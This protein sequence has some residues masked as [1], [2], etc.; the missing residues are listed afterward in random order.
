MENK[1]PA[2][3]PRWFLIPANAFVAGGYSGYVING[4]MRP[5][6][7]EKDVRRKI[8]EYDFK[9]DTPKGFYILKA[10]V[11]LPVF[12][13]L[14]P[15]L[16]LLRVLSKEKINDRIIKF[17]QAAFHFLFPF[18]RH[19]SIT[20]EEINR[21]HDQ[22]TLYVDIPKELTA[23]HEAG[24]RIAL[25]G[26]GGA[27]SQPS[28][29]INKQM[30][31]GVVHAWIPG[32]GQVLFDFIRANADP[33]N[34]I[35]VFPSIGLY[36]NVIQHIPVYRVFKQQF[37]VWDPG[38]MK[39][40]IPEIS[41]SLRQ[42]LER[43]K[44]VYGDSVKVEAKAGRRNSE[45]YY[46][47][48]EGD[49]L[50]RGFIEDN[51]QKLKS[52]F[53]ARS[54]SFIYFPIDV[55]EKKDEYLDQL[56]ENLWFSAPELRASD[57]S[58]AR[59]ETAGIFSKADRVKIERCFFEDSGFP[60]F[61]G[62]VLVKYIGKN[63][64]TDEDL[65]TYVALPFFPDDSLLQNIVSFSDRL[66]PN[67]AGELKIKSKPQKSSD[68]ASVNFYEKTTDP[69]RDIS[70]EDLVKLQR[71]QEETGK[72]RLEEKPGLF[73]ALLEILT[74]HTDEKTSKRIRELLIEKTSRPHFSPLLITRDYGII[75]PDYGNMEISM[76]PLAKI[77]YF[78][79]LRHPEGLIFKNLV[80]HREE[81][82]E[83]YE[84]ITGRI[85]CSQVSRSIDDLVDATSPSVNQKA[86]RIRAAFRSRM[87]EEI[88]AHYYITGENSFPKRITA[89][90]G[91][92]KDE[93][94][95]I[96][97]RNT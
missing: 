24:F 62:P 58:R 22:T 59:M 48:Y 81:L 20:Y 93:S 94:G 69:E 31:S 49:E 92:L 40:E 82:C 2:S 19:K 53:E 84:K 86:A 28:P 74:K 32:S 85:V 57:F 15:V 65:F 33:R 72:L 71:I 67:H 9:P 14:S 13:L 80:D 12:L 1:I 3:R 55:E 54:L 97:R 70:R 61:G 79:F 18:Y 7:T 56:L 75:L 5:E 66:S 16:L 37:F 88:A 42:I 30:N 63:H 35:V 29:Y 91:F 76:Y 51:H 73:L 64:S 17:I 50:I 11:L 90:I 39:K 83:L 52:I 25:Y 68:K 96:I 78:L 27:G 8:T 60:D 23:I 87:P 41:S 34:S 38:L 46:L 10:F 6:I 77:L 95:L 89:A 21:Q 26:I 43:S 45:V 36:E 4:I 44:A 47:G